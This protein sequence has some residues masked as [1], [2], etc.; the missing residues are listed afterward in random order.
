MDPADSIEIDPSHTLY[1]KREKLSHI[2]KAARSATA[3]NILAPL[4]CI[5]VFHDEVR[6]PYFDAWLGY[7]LVVIVWRTWIIFGL[8]YRPS[9]ILEPERDLNKAAFAIGMVG[10]GWG[11][12]WPLMT[13]DLSLVNRMIYV[14]MTTAA[15]ISSM[16]AYSVDSRTFFTFTLTIMVPAATTFLWSLDIFPWPFSV[17]LASLY[18]VVLSIARNFSKVFENSVRLRFRNER[19]YQELVAERD[20]SIAA[21]VAKSKFIAAASHDLRQ[22]LHAINI[23]LELIHSK[24]LQQQDGLL[25]QKIKN[26]IT[27]LNSMF[28]ALLN[29]SKLDS[30]T[31]KLERTD[32]KLGDLA[33]SVREVAYAHAVK[34]GLLLSIDAPPW[35]IRGDKLVFQQILVNLV[36]NAIQYTR[37]GQVEVKFIAVKNCLAFQVIDTGLGISLEDQGNI[38]NE[39]QR[40]RHTRDLHEGLGLGLTIVK[41]LCDL[42]DASIHVS[43]GLGQGSTFSVTTTEPICENRPHSIDHSNR[44]EETTQSVDLKGK[45]IAI[46]EDDELIADAYKHTLAALGARVLS[47]SEMDDELQLQLGSI[48]RIDCILSDYRLRHTTGDVIIEK[49]RENFNQEIP[50]IIVT[51]DTA[52]SEI[53]VF[54]G[55][56]ATVLYKP[57]TFKEIVRALENATSRA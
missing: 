35:V 22:P 28:E 53:D 36:M 44:L 42:M 26:S 14:Y 43:S 54:H 34:K 45:C 20:Q 33:D 52:A 5:P 29:M 23:N 9:K 39:F 21:N 1:L 25:L 4:L 18:V 7:M 11:L 32:F 17:G 12:G 15:M 16:F 24:H 8:E 37:E 41:R 40:A 56:R 49:L 31:T 46:I 30:F 57:L 10:L 51:A 27:V 38:F 47:L 19:L 13:P 55:I 48:D 3:A 6:A 50:A 2:V